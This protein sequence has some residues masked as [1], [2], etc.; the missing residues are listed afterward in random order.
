LYEAKPFSYRILVARV[1]ATLRRYKA[2]RRQPCNQD[3]TSSK[4]NEEISKDGETTE[5]E[6]GKVL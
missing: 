1:K 4:A 5:Q 3:S 2:R 6:K